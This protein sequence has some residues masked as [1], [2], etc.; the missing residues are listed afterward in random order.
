M[1]KSIPALITPEVLIWARNLDGIAIEDAAAR[2]KVKPGKIESWENGSEYPTL[3]QAKDLAKYYRIPFVTLY[4][5]DPPKKA[6]RIDKVDFRTF[7]NTGSMILPSRE[8]RWLLRDVEDRR[9]SILELFEMDERHP[10]QF[11][12]HMSEN[13]SINDVASAIRS[14]LELTPEVQRKFRK[15][16][17]ALAYCINKLESFDVLVFQ[18]AKIDP[19]EM[20][21]LSIGYDEMPIIV[22]NRKDEYSARLFT[23]IHEVVHIVLGNT[24]ICNDI[25]SSATT[26]NTI[27]RFCNEV[28]GLVLAP[29]EELKSHPVLNNI[30]EYGLDDVYVN[31]IARDFAVSKE[32]VLYNLCSL[33]VITNDEYFDTLHRYSDEYKEYAS[34]KKSGQIPPAIDKGSQV[35]RLYAR[36]VLEAYH[37]DRITVRDASAY[38]LNLGIKHFGNIERWCL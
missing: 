38:L 19:R 3:R 9:D 17:K 7:G 32:V 35:G 13:D 18:A 34:K 14:L 27:E 26:T 4:L 22:L 33:G 31:A 15:P 5:P 10:K 8:L 2:L 24:G 36:T 16:E 25:G 11:P 37:N 1:G 12:I 21:G 28:A 20:R 30:I 6:K 29:V 23:L